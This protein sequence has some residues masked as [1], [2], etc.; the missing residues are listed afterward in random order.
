M[1]F[2]IIIIKFHTLSVTIE[3]DFPISNYIYS[4]YN[5]SLAIPNKE[6][7]FGFPVGD[8][9]LKICKVILENGKITKPN[10]SVCLKVYKNSR[11]AS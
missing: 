5:M 1:G 2:V 6:D 10:W 9:H 11:F 7:L 3:I 4:W 8:L